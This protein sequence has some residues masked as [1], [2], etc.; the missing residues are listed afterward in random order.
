MRNSASAGLVDPGTGQFEGEQV[1]DVIRPVQCTEQNL[2]MGVVERRDE[3]PVLG[4]LV[5]TEA[6][7][8]QPLVEGL[9]RGIAQLREGVANH[10]S[11]MK[12][13]RSLFVNSTRPCTFCCSTISWCLSAAFSAS[14][15]LL[16]LKG[17][18]IKLKGGISARPSRPTL[19]DSVIKSKW[20]RFFGTH[21]RARACGRGRIANQAEQFH[22][23]MKKLA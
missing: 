11:W 3:V 15:R 22:A 1:G 23:P 9:D 17:E 7:W 6:V 2:D 20:T 16:D 5:V 14:S 12:N 21:S 13:R 4:N 10:N 8:R 19:S 18:A